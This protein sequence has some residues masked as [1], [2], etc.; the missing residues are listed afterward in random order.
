MKFPPLLLIF[1]I[2]ISSCQN[3]SDVS[4]DDDIFETVQP[5]AVGLENEFVDSLMNRV[6]RISNIYSCLILKDGKIIAEKY[7]NG[8]DKNSLLHIRSITKS[9]SSILIGIAIDEGHLSGTDQKLSKYYLEYIK[10]RNGNPLYDITLEHLLDMQSGFDWNESNEAIPWYTSVRDSW[11]YIFDKAVVSEPG[12][13][14]N[15]N[16]G[17]T[18]LL[19]RFIESNQPLAYD[20]YAS[21]N[22]FEPLGIN[23]W[24]WDQDGLGNYRADAGLQLRAVDLAKVGYLMMH[25]GEFNRNQVVSNEWVETSWKFAHDLEGAYGE[26]E[27][28]HYNNLWW[29]GTMFETEVFFGLG[30]G[31][32]LLLCVP[33]HDLVVVSNHEFRLP[34]NE[35]SQHSS[36][37]IELVFKP[38]LEHVIN[39]G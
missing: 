15:Y 6:N 21:I 4:I 33:E 10:P 9:I 28:V 13:E 7:L 5:E 25:A 1:I 23:E 32:Q 39:Q 27:N 37:F 38:I 31:G 18:S 29:M 22:L 19:T 8:A 24:N 30:Y 3:E 36:R 11:S 34:A 2:I 14:F 26:I 16:S 17:A 35:T 20:K 12:T